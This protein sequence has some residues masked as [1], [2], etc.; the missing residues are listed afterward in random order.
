ME[1]PFEKPPVSQNDKERRGEFAPNPMW[2]DHERAE[3]H[4]DVVNSGIKE[5]RE[6]EIAR[7]LGRERRGSIDVK[8]YESGNDR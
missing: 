6:E 8:G 4:G 5:T 3:D 2:A 7:L 1:M